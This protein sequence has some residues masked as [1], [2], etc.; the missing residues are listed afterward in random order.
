MHDPFDHREPW[1]TPHGELL[2]EPARAGD[3]TELLRLF[4]E[5]LSFQSSYFLCLHHYHTDE[6]ALAA[7]RD[8]LAAHARREAL[9]YVARQ[10]AEVV[11]YFFLVRLQSP[12]GLPSS[13]GIGLADRLHGA[14]IGGRFMDLLI[15]AAREMGHREIVL[16]HHPD[17]RR[18]AAL[19]R[20]KGFEYTGEGSEWMSPDGLRREPRMRLELG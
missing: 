7:L 12:D 3:E 20:R 5:R 15:E 4:R 11:G 2:I 6:Q 8:R 19:Y 9:V 18:A 10:G 13:L 14:W 1:E 16:T 17:N